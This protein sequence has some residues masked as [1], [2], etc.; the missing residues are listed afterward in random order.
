MDKNYIAEL[1]EK[2]AD[3]YEKLGVEITP[4]GAGVIDGLLVFSQ[5]LKHKNGFKGE[6]IEEDVKLHQTMLSLLMMEEIKEKV[7]N[8]KKQKPNNN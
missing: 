3:S 7:K 4:Y 8:A 5:L 6:N 2:T 1:A